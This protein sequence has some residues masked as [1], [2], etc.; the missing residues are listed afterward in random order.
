MAKTM[1]ASR[2]HQHITGHLV[3]R[4][5]S[6]VTLETR[7]EAYVPTSRSAVY[8]LL[9]RNRFSVRVA[10]MKRRPDVDPDKL[11]EWIID[12]QQTLSAIPLRYFLNCDE[13]G[14]RLV[15]GGLR[16]WAPV[17][18]DDVQI[19]HRANEKESFTAMACIN[20]QLQKL[21]LML[22]A[23]GKTRRCEKS[24]GD[25]TPSR[26]TH[27]MNGWI[28]TGSM[29]EFMGGLRE[30]IPGF[31]DFAERDDDG[32][33]VHE[34]HLMLDSHKVHLVDAVRQRA[35]ELQIVL[36]F[37]PVGMTDECQPLDRAVFGVLKA[38]QR[39]MFREEV[40]Q[41]PARVG[42]VKI[43]KREAAGMRSTP[44]RWR[45]RGASTP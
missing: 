40:T 4:Y 39:R 9:Q 32:F 12:M 30:L 17:G 10:H 28:T 20:A 11:C 36:H 13:T 34:L 7:G 26:T 42:A 25:V 14:V 38:K 24:F 27:T 43:S 22:I 41:N 33:F 31:E 3:T 29:N 45:G 16:T 1:Q 8:R 35:A 2:R 37:V 23:K 44:V 15:P 5:I 21:P 19:E 18:E 6:Q